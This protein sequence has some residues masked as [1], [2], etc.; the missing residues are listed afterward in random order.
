MKAREERVPTMVPARLRKGTDWHDATILNLSANGL[1][2]HCQEPYSRGHFLEI[3]RG[4]HVIVAQVMW[5]E[6]G[7]VGARTQDEL[8]VFAII[9][10]RP[11]RR[12]SF[13]L[14]VDRR[15]ER[16]P[17]S[18]ERSRQQ[19]RMFEYAVAGLLAVTASVAAFTM[20]QQFFASPVSRIEAALASVR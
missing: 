13:G 5:S 17:P 6:A 9:N 20:V 10:D 3:R 8:E 15:H 4:R 14:A 1:M 18:G 16:R 7:K 2:F 19:A 12:R 11:A